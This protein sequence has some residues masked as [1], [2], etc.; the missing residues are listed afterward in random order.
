MLGI[1][2]VSSVG[3]QIP[4]R[5]WGRTKDRVGRVNLLTDPTLTLAGGERVSLP[6]LF[7]A[8]AAG[9]VRGFPALRPH[10]RPAW[11]MFLVQLGALALWRNRSEVWSPSDLPAD[12][13][14]WT[15]ALRA[16]TMDHRDDSPWRL[17]VDDE[18]KPAFLQPPAPSGLSWSTVETADALDLLI[19]AR[20]HDLK[21]TVARR[22]SVE[23]WVFALVSL[24]TTEGYGGKGNHG[25]ARMNGGSSSRPLLGFAPAPKQETSVDPAAWWARDVTKLLALRATGNEHC[26]GTAGGPAVLWCLAWPEAEQLDLL[27]LDPWFIEVCRRIRLSGCTIISGRRSTSKATRIDAK[28]F[29]GSVGDPWA[30]VHKTEGKSFTLSGGDFDYRRLCSL[31]FSGEW[32]V[33]ALA[34]HDTSGPES[35][36]LVAEALSRG[37]AKTEGFKSRVLPIPGR[38]AR[39]MFSFPTA[40]DLSRS[41]MAEVEQFDK[42]LRTSLALVAARG[43]RELLTKDHYRFS[44]PAQNR[45]NHEVDRLFFPSLWRRVAAATDPAA[46]HREKTAFLRQLRQAAQA[47]F[48]AALPAIPCTAIQRPRAEAR[49]RR[50]FRNALW[51]AYPELFEQEESRDT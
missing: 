14:F 35:M 24:Q 19:T 51:R 1:D 21:Q 40:A 23:D 12:P 32:E 10:Q 39:R 3:T 34:R 20:N 9:R 47:E 33:P 27:T 5:P 31:L 48:D 25:I 45:F 46:A 43:D 18:A 44:R 42:A 8:L 11:H 36:L 2:L 50:R 4:H 30:P 7:A 16:L 22:A 17:V 6:G 15:A 13:A 38:V 29:Q 41:Q 37:N 49:S 26:L 28:Q